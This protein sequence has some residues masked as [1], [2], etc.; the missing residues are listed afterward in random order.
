MVQ[1]RTGQVEDVVSER[2]GLQ[3]VM[4]DGEPAYALTAIVGELAV[5]D[6]VIVN[7]TAVSLGL[8]TGGSHVV[9][10]NLN[11]SELGRP[12]PGHLMKARYLS[13]Q[14]DT[15][16]WDEHSAPGPDD[17]PPGLPDLA[18]IPVAVCSLHSH[19]AVVAAAVRSRLAAARVGYV[20]TDAASL[21]L[22]MS[23][24]VAELRSCGLLSLS[25]SSGQAF[26]GDLEALTPASGVEACAEAGMDAVIVAMGPG[27]AGTGSALGFTGLEVVGLVDLLNGLGARATPVVRWSDSD[28]RRRHQGLSHH[29]R[30]VLSLLARPYEVPVPPTERGRELAGYLAQLGNQ[31]RAVEVE[32]ADPVSVL[33][34]HG[35][36]VRSMGRL[37]ADD[38]GAVETLAAVGTWVGERSEERSEVA[39]G[40]PGGSG[41][42]SGQ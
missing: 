12:G 6:P 17:P 40:T 16:A 19:V 42:L 34:R 37:L 14:I 18:G 9:H 22:V 38:R 39:T 20:M 33:D 24:L 36:T 2:P 15:G 7:T 1:F 29:S 10:W 30:T 8:G 32:M 3:R 25:V 23:D 5:G 31:G 13:E 35:L 27:H 28:P 11:R 26:G 4:V 21:P 41:S